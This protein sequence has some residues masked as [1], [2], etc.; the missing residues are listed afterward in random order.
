MAN[1][2]TVT[3]PWEVVDDIVT[4]EL[5]S[6]VESV[7]KD[8]WIC[9]HDYAETLEEVDCFLHVMSCMLTREEMK[10]YKQSI[11]EQYLDLV[12]KAYPEEE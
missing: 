5:Q 9:H 12:E 2:V 10:L 1:G 6:Y 4:N 3:L 11:M 8:P 7:L